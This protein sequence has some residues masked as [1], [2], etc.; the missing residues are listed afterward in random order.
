MNKT[1]IIKEFNIKDID[2][3]SEQI[4]KEVTKKSK[5]VDSIIIQL[6]IEIVSLNE[7]ILNNIGSIN[8]FITNTMKSTGEIMIK[9]ME[10]EIYTIAIDGP[11]ASGKSTISK[12]LSGI[13]GIDY[14]DTGAMYRAITYYLLNNDIDIDDEIQIEESINKIKLEIHDEYILID[15]LKLKDEL[16]TEEITK[17]V[18]KVSSYRSVRKKLVELQ[19]EIAKNNSIVL[20]GRDIG[21]IVLPNADYKFYIVASA[22]ERA[23]RR[24]NDT[25]SKLDM[26]FEEILK[27]I[28][29]RDNID[30]NREISPLKKANDAIL[31][32]TSNMDIK[33]VVE[34][35]IRQ[36]RGIEC[37]GF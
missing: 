4:V 21:T 31:I 2:G 30:M 15:N 32:D 33:E 29:R 34:Y 1:V 28:I 20:D 18:S 19:Q 36:I 6:P 7:K 3:L 12:I 16:R 37:I 9:I 17:N 23:K 13:L 35:I 27:D 8:I 22:E 24:L 5:I 11:S 14:L 10:K 25:N 26:S